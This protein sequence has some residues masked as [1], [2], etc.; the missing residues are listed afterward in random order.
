MKTGILIVS[1][2]TTYRETREKNIGKLAQ[3]VRE[4][5]ADALVLEAYSSEIVRKV[6]RERDGIIIPD[7]KDALCEMERQGIRRVTVLPTHIIDGIENNKMKQAVKECLGM[8]DEIKVAD[9]LLTTGEDYERTALALWDSLREAAGEDPVILMGHGSAHEADKSYERFEEVLNRCASNDIYVATVEGSVDIDSV[10]ARLTASKRKSGRVFVTPFMLVAGDHAENDM[11]GE[12]ESFAAKLKEAGYEPECLLKGIGEYEKIQ[13]LYL[14]HLQRAMDGIMQGT[15]YGIG[16]GPGDPELMTLKALRCIKESDIVILPAA[17]KEKCHAYRIVEEVCPEIREKEL[18]CLPFPM[19][20]EK[21]VLKAAH[22]EIYLRIA[23]FL[24]EGRTVAFLTIGDPSVYSTYSYIHRRVEENGGKAVMVS[25]VPSF[26]AA[27]GALGISLGDNRDEI[28]VIPGSYEIAKTME[29]TG[30]RVYMKSGKRLAE[31]KA[32]LTE[33][34]K[35]TPL[36]VYCVENCGMDTE[37]RT[38]GID[39]LDPASGYLTIVI[40]KEKSL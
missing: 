22:R 11:A 2:G 18:L 10:L 15:L 17:E 27:A 8:F 31:L 12:E 16:V 37:R 6:L 38:Y 1:F 9:A 20:K 39:G 14:E 5:Y 36:E 13:E 30:T 34:T 25:G 7:V 29:L 40:V 23:G 26:C 4:K 3:I 33:Q 35:E 19:T 28:H 24:Q 32:A 21:E